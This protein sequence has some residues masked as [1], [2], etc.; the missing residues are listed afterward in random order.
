MRLAVFIPNPRER[1]V[2]SWV[3]VRNSCFCLAYLP[4]VEIGVQRDNIF[5]LGA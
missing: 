2:G 1:R 3:I 4:A 5:G